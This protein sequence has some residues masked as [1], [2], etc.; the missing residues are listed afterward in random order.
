MVSRLILNL[1]N[2]AMRPRAAVVSYPSS[3]LPQDQDRALTSTVIGNLG[4]PVETNWFDYGDADDDKDP[5][6]KDDSE[7]DSRRDTYA[8]RNL[9]GADTAASL[10]TLS[11]TFTVHTTDRDILERT[12]VALFA[13]QPCRG[14]SS[15]RRHLW[16]DSF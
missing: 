16:A 11:R 14:P 6:D 13:F 10:P 7:V 3:Q 1:R 15:W 12:L 4:E 8:M 9:Y 5:K 2:Q